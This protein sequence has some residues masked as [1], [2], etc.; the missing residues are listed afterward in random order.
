MTYGYPYW[1]LVQDVQ[2][3][4]RVL[5][6]AWFVPG[7]VPAVSRFAYG[8]WFVYYSFSQFARGGVIY[9]GYFRF[10]DWTT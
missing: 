3:P 6:G 5:N 10:G 2:P 8:W 1:G 9:R 7:L 4:T